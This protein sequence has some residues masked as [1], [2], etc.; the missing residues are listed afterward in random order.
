MVATLTLV[1][2]FSAITALPY[3]HLERATAGLRAELRRQPLAADVH[4]MPM[5]ETFEVTG[6]IQFTDLRGRTW[7][8]YRATVESRRAVD[9]ATPVV[10]PGHIPT[11]SR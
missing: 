4:L 6:R 9:C 5:W 10:P 1:S 7:Y 11:E 3:E 2:T 8:E